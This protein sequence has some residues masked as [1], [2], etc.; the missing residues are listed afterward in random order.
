MSSDM[1]T[2]LMA[3]GIV[4]DGV[5]AYFSGQI[6]SKKGHDFATYAVLG[7]LLPIIGIIIAAALPDRVMQQTIAQTAAKG[8]KESG[9]DALIKYKA[10]LDDGAITQEEFDRMKRQILDGGS[11]VVIDED[12]PV[13]VEVIHM[14]NGN[15]SVVL[16]DGGK[17]S[18]YGRMWRNDT[19]RDKEMLTSEIADEIAHEMGRK[20]FYTMVVK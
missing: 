18:Q 15:V 4:V 13:S 12:N 9:A 14:R 3:M 11:P 5:L 6:A 19:N 17:R 7:V 20:V 16:I 1:S 2:I 10:L 8:N